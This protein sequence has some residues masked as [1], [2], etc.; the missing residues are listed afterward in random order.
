M[1]REGVEL[2]F[3]TKETANPCTLRAA[4]S[5][6]RL[7]SRNSPVLGLLCQLSAFLVP[8][9]NPV[10]MCYHQSIS[11]RCR[12]HPSFS[13]EVTEHCSFDCSAVQTLG[14]STQAVLQ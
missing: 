8:G 1:R 14:S 10:A 12:A 11:A 7:C 2:L 3:N 13:Q 4:A 9:G 5:G 6:N